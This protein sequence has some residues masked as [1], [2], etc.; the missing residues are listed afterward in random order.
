M[1]N[2]ATQAKTIEKVLKSIDGL[3]Y[4]TVLITIHEGKIVQIDR[5]EKSR[6]ELHKK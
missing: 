5:T 4:G 2:D 1:S 3:Q 6:F